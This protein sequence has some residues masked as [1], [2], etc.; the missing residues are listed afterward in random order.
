M[1]NTLTQTLT[2][3]A[4]NDVA[5]ARKHGEIAIAQTKLG[6]LGLAHSNGTY[7]LTVWGTY[8]QQPRTLATGKPAVII[9]VLVSNYA[10]VGA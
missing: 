4:K 9:P 3:F 10:V 1:E 5:M 6:T 8:T 2:R 7:T